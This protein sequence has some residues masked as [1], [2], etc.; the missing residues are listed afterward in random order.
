MPANPENRRSSA[1]S[2]PSDGLCATGCQRK[3]L[4]DAKRT[5]LYHALTRIG[6]LQDSIKG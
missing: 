3:V 4:N 2:T 5:T 6:W 1:Q